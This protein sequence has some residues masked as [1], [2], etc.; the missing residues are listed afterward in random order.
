MTPN[1]LVKC[2]YYI[3]GR[4]GY[5]FYSSKDNTNDYLNYVNNGVKQGQVRDY[6]DYA[7]NKEKSS[8]AFS[9]SGLLTVK[10]KKDIREKLKNTNAQIW[11]IL[12]SFEEEYGKIHMKS[13]L[14][15]KEIIEKEFPTF[16]KEN[17]IEYSNITWFAGLHENTDNRHIHICFFENVPLRIIANKSE[18]IYHHGKLKEDSINRLK[19]RI[20]QRMSH[21]EYDIKSERNKI[22]TST[23]TYLDSL[24]DPNVLFDKELKNKLL[25]L[26]KKMP[27]GP[28]GYESKKMD[29]VRSDIDDIT[30]HYLTFDSKA[31]LEYISFLKKLNYYDLKT[32][33]ICQSQKIDSIEFLLTPKFKKDLYRR[34][35]NKV[36]N[37]VR[38]S[39]SKTQIFRRDFDISKVKR[40]NEKKKVTYLLKKSAYLTI[41]VNKERMDIFDEFERKMKEYELEKEES[42]ME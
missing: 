16:L 33:E 22:I 26:Y 23:A 37:F 17:R 20:E 36:I 18:R 14:D 11:S 6:I 25:T 32:K 1:V 42:E 27:D 39:K 5:S 41:E 38:T 31:K 21:V 3:L 8:G 7:G 30:T 29:I 19:V 12:I 28:F 9:S 4:K 15:A 40:F 34:I 2:E 10:E 13:Y 24:V 35:G